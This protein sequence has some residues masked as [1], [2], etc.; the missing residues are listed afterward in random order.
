VVKETALGS[1]GCTD[2]HSG[3]GALSTPIPVT[4]KHPVE[5]PGMGML[6]MPTYHY[7][8]YNTKALTALGLETQCEDVVAGT[9]NIDVDGDATLIREGAVEMLL[10]WLMPNAPGGYLPADDAGVLA[11]VGLATS[12]LA[13]NGGAWMA[14]LEPV[15]DYVPNYLV[16]GYA[17][18]EIFGVE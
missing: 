12:D 16:L 8:F 10:N 14:V 9:A 3:N 13:R 18:G 11:D 17:P 4:R 2:C 5:I 15:V 7:V 1:G 6:E